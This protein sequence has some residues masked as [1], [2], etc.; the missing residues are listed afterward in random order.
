MALS[1]AI[2]LLSLSDAAFFRSRASVAPPQTLNIPV[3]L[4]ANQVYSVRVNMSSSAPQPFH[5]ALST[6]TAI[7]TVVGSTCNSCNGAPS[8]DPNA[9]SS[10]QQLAG[11]LPQNVSMPGFSAGGP[12]LRE[13]CALMTQNGSAWLYPNQTVTISNHSVASAFGG[14]V[15]GMIGLGPS[16][17]DQ[18][19]A[20][21]W[22]AKN[23]AQPAFQVGFA[24]TKP[25]AANASS[26]SDDEGVDGG[27][28]HWLCPDENAY[29]GDVS[30]LPMNSE[31]QEPQTADNLTSWNVLMDGWSAAGTSAMPGTPFNIT[32]IG[33]HLSA[34]LDPFYPNVVF[35]QSAARSIYSNIPG[36]VPLPFGLTPFTNAWSIPCDTKL[37]LSITFGTFTTSLNQA[38]LVVPLG[39]GQ[40]VGAL[41]EWSDGTVSRYLLGAPFIASIYLILSYAQSG[42]GSLGFAARS[43]EA[44]KKLSQG[45]IAGVSLGAIAV[46]LLLVIAATLV[47]GICRRRHMA[48][49]TPS[50]LWISSNQKS[51]KKR[52]PSDTSIIEPFPG[53]DADGA[54]YARYPS[55][56]GQQL[57][58]GYGRG[59]HSPNSPRAALL[60]L[61]NSSNG[62]SPD[63]QT[64]IFETSPDTNT[65]A[66]GTAIPPT[67][68]T[69]Y[70]SYQTEAMSTGRDQ[71]VVGQRQPQGVQHVYVIH[72]M[73]SRELRTATSSTSLLATSASVSHQH[74]GQQQQQHPNLNGPL[75]PLPEQQQQQ[76]QQMP[77]STSHGSLIDSF[78]SPPPYNHNRGQS[79]VPLAPLR[80]PRR[81]S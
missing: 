31:S 58:F 81:S 60:D 19:P 17:F 4:D 20:A 62:T 78:D 9:S 54:Q 34:F 74:H 76:Q 72:N 44:S 70:L 1:Y 71:G 26:A 59:Q 33:T 67:A 39:T 2:I 46:V 66:G 48:K 69:R 51:G 28:L 6:T 41:Q 53:L 22:L 80:K 8:Y 10:V 25:L 23:P 7:T 45:V 38:V 32:Q 47:Y 21:H 65:F 3:R 12:V 16:P 68:D 5:F 75:P 79:P 11:S 40:C 36:S 77:S 63:W 52:K 29:E 30:W 49:H 42:A 50:A 64:T 43:R 13:D 18:S 15:S 24:L 57:R 73:S 35:P 37:T 61:N 27:T 14:L 56:T 55:P